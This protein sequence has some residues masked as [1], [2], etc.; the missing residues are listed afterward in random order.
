MKLSRFRIQERVFNGIIEGDSVRVADADNQ[1]AE[2]SFAISELEALL[3]VN[4]SKI[5]CVGRNYADHAKELGNAVPSEPLLFLKAPS[6][7]I[8][9]NETIEIPRQSTRVEHEGELAVVIGKDCKNVGDDDDPL[10]YVLGFTCLN[11]VTARDIQRNDVQFTRGK[12][13]DTFCPVGPHIE[14][15]LDTADLSIVTK[16]NGEIRQNGRTSQMIFPVEH[17]LR[18]ISRQMSLVAGDVIATGTPA[19]VSKMEPGDICEIS[20]EGIGTLSNRVNSA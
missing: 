14:T 6:A 8:K 1:P 19:G 4:P 18:Y 17:L 2:E 16:I 20:I 13:F 9:Q 15:E 11:D 10:K 5:V 3:P 12:S 7:L